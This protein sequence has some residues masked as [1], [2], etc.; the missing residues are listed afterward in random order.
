MPATPLR[1]A[2]VQGDTRWQDPAGN[3][4]H[5]GALIRDIREPADLIVLPET[6]ATGFTNAVELAEGPEGPSAA[7]MADQAR[8]TGA[9]VAG[10]LLIRDGEACFN[11]FLWICPDGTSTF[12]DK[13]HLFRMAGEHRIFTPG[14][15]RVVVELQ[16]WKLLLQVCYDL[17]FPVWSRNRAA[18]GGLDYDALLYVANWPAPRRTPWRTLLRARAIEN[19]AYAL[20]VNRAGTDGNG[21]PYAGDTAAVDFQGETLGEL[22]PEPGVL[23]LTLDPETLRLHR[24]RF[25]AWRDG[26][27]FRIEGI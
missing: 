25:P 2:L 19:H 23:T 20:G 17:R 8:V 10:S 15:A 16:G 24:E 21:H 1:V 6:W 14:Q 12:Y 5:Y 27:A 3:R 22:G 18:E 13:R 26:D 7:W 4:E 9:V 11:R